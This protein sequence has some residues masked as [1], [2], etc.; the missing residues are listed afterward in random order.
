MG[1][2][3]TGANSL[4]GGDCG[5]PEVADLFATG[6]NFDTDGSCKD[7]ATDSAAGAAFTTV[8]TA[9]LNLGDLAFDPPG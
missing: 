8:T 5:G 6:A 7:A 1:G 2:V 4:A 3:D 9:D